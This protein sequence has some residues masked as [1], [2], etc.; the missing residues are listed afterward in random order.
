[1]TTMIKDDKV[2]LRL[3]R[4]NGGDTAIYK[5]FLL[6]LKVRDNDTWQSFL[7]REVVAS[8]ML[9]INPSD[10]T[11]LDLFASAVWIFLYNK[12]TKGNPLQ[13]MDIL[14]SRMEGEPRDHGHSWLTSPMSLYKRGR[15]G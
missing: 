8:V 10:D 1:M 11:T 9:G 3:D 6:G 2:E 12:D 15:T 4:V 7:R 14:E 13:L 5:K